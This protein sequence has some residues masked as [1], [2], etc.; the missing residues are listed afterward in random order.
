MSYVYFIVDEDVADATEPL[1]KIGW[2]RRAPAKRLHEIQRYA[3]RRLILLAVMP[4]GR[5][6][7]RRLHERYAYDRAHGEWFDLESQTWDLIR[8]VQNVFGDPSEDGEPSRRPGG[9]WTIEELERRGAL[10]EVVLAR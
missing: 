2:T 10:L 1:V 8:G 5:E 4:G 3:S 7:E 6:T 9:R